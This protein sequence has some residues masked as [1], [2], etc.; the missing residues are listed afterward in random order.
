MRFKNYIALLCLVVIGSVWFIE[1]EISH[2]P[3]RNNISTA[4]APSLKLFYYLEKYSEEYDVPFQIAYGIAY[5]ETGYRGPFHWSYN[6]KLTS[7]ANAYGAM[8]I[9]VPTAN[10]FADKKVTSKDLLE[11]LELN[12]IL[13][14]RAISYLKD[15]YGS[16]E[17]AL[18]AYNTGKPCSNQYARDIVL[19]LN[20]ER[21]IPTY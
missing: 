14:M 10:Y 6:P 2:E 17:L 11:N 15:K 21:K 13:S 16:W 20:N 12:V 18:G 9:Q 1:R 19:R 7:S 3:E 4:K 5:K 8:Q